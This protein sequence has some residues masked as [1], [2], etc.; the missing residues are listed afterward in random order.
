MDRVSAP[1]AGYGVGGHGLC[2]GGLVSDGPRHLRPAALRLGVLLGVQVALGILTT[3]LSRGSIPV[4]PGTLHQANALALL[5]L[6]LFLRQATRASRLP[7]A[8]GWRN[9]AV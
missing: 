5:V 9:C 1:L 3:V 8:P 4:L 2:A 6:V 7:H